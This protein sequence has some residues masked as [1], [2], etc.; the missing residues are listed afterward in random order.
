MKV[1]AITQARYNST[2]LPG[3]VLKKISDRTLLQIHLERI[4]QSKLI[5]KI[6]VATTTEPEASA[7]VDICEKMG[8]EAYKGSI[9]D[10][11]DRFYQTALPEKPDYIVRMTSDCPLIDAVEID[12]VINC[13][14][15][16]DCDYVS[17]C[18]EPTL[19]DGLDV[20]VFRFSALKKAFLEAKL[21]SDRE[22][23][24]PYIERN[25]T[26][27]NGTLFNSFS[28]KNEHDFSQYRLTVDETEDF[29]LIE[30][31]IQK[32]G[33]DKGWKDYIDY[34]NKNP[35]ILNINSKFSRNE[36]YQRSLENDK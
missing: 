12:K 1:L 14:L 26:V 33:I 13:I 34:I 31:L 17:N 6:K 5:S 11:L 30:I 7:I 20:E 27:N 32:L 18:M 25:S 4:K 3:K 24:T 19:P 2:R 28:Y 23:V 10:V 36:G 29:D 22:H 9:D 35:E 16:N 15:N 8:I 21:K